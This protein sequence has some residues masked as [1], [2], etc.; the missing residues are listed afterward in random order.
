MADVDIVIEICGMAGD[1]VISGG[2][3]LAR[4]MSD[5]GFDIMSF[6]SY[7]AEIRGFG[8]CVAHSR[9]GN[10]AILSPGKFAD[11]PISLDDSHAIGQLSALRET[12]VVIYD[13]QPRGYLEEDQSIAGWIEPGMTSYGVPLLQLAQ[14]AAGDSRGRNMVALGALAALFGI[15]PDAMIATLQK[16][17]AKK[18]QVVID[19]NVNSF[20]EGHTWTKENIIKTDRLTFGGVPTRKAD[21]AIMSGNQAVVRAALDSVIHLYAGYPIT[22]ATGILQDLARTLP[23]RGGVV[24]QTEDEISA[25]GH[26]VGA[27]FAGKRAM[28]A[29]SGPGLCLMSE[30]INYASMA[31][32]PAVIV[33]SQRGG[34]S[35]GLPTKTEQSD[36]NIALFG[37]SGDSPRF[38]IAPTTVGE[39]YDLTCLAFYLAE[40]YQ[41]PVIL[42]LDFFL[43]RS[44]KNI[45]HPKVQNKKW[46]AA[47]VAPSKADLKD[48]K[49]YKIT[50]SGISPRALP[51]T[52]GAMHVVTGL[53]HDEKGTPAYDKKTH[54]AMTAK[55]YR[56]LEAVLAEAPR[57]EWFGDKEKVQVGVLAWG[58]TVGAA[59]EAVIR[60]RAAGIRAAAF[61]TVMMSPM[62]TD[63]IKEFVQACDVVLVPEG[64]FTGQFA[65]LLDG[66]ITQQFARLSQLVC[67]P[68]P[69]EDIFQTIMQLAEENQAAGGGQRAE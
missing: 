66:L 51:G 30:F 9:I 2:E 58:S 4:C 47:N 5:Q 69:A 52:P 65:N 50:D 55:R 54:T 48:Y 68:M 23:L 10:N 31:E 41:T 40:K 64:N 26:V 14:K 44:L 38:V 39:C 6:D 45:D 15:N 7:P 22:P 67:A 16:R 18:K 62:F 29:T 43:S 13:S 53:E 37:A 34:P 1:G 57:P 32:C 19:N 24:V 17:Y 12:G 56:K 42:L 27:C 20:T 3:I 59:R 25:I 33:N 63:P 11:I 21:K 8:K 36:L 61:K 49:R 28:T 46:L 60:A 35:T